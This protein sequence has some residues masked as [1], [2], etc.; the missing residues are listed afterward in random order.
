VPVTGLL[1]RHVGEARAVLDQIDRGVQRAQAALTSIA[2]P[3]EQLD[4]VAISDDVKAQIRDAHRLREQ[5]HTLGVRVRGALPTALCPYDKNLQRPEDADC[6]F[7]GGFGYVTRAQL[8]GATIP[9]ELMRRGAAAMVTDHRGGFVS[10]E[11][12]L[13]RSSA[14]R[15][16]ATEA[17][18]VKHSRKQIAQLDDGTAV[19]DDQVGE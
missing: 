15:S 12:Q 1:L 4:G 14:L 6:A 10:F 5:L 16:A 17:A 11:S 8:E 18:G 9:H 7:C 19:Y 13:A 3:L 2:G